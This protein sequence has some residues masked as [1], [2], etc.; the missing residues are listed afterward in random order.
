MIKLKSL[1]FLSLI[2]WAGPLF[3]ESAQA[4]EPHPMHWE[5]P[6]LAEGDDTTQLRVEDYQGKIVYV[7]FWAS[8]CR[9]CIKSM[10]FLNALRDEF[11]SRGFEVLAV[12]VDQNKADALSF[13]Q[14]HPVNY[15]VAHDNS[16]QLLKHLNVVGLPSAFLLDADG[17]PT[18]V[19][20]GFKESDKAYLRAMIDRALA[21]NGN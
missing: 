1:L 12:N 2:V 11:K 21:I 8:W 16:S 13:L 20:A 9:P 10:P 5:L 4:S 15:P 7:D 17:V 19:H 6:L 18:L 14:K 3:G